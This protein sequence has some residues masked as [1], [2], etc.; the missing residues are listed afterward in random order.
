[1]VR[2]ANFGS[3]HQAL[4]SSSPTAVPTLH[5]H[6][7]GAKGFGMSLVQHGKTIQLN[8]RD[9]SPE[10]KIPTVEDI[11]DSLESLLPETNMPSLRDSELAMAGEATSSSSNLFKTLLYSFTN[12]FAGPREVP[13]RS[14]MQLVREQHEMRTQL[15]E[16]IKSSQSG[17]AKS[18]ADNFF[19][20]AVEGCDADAV[21]TIIHHTKDNPSMA[22]DPNEIACNFEGR[23]F[24][25]IELAA[26]FRNTELVRI[27][28]SPA[29]IPTRHMGEN[30][31]ITGRK[32]R[33][34]LL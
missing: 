8:E 11:T 2:D 30:M 14:L 16:Y 13:R 27:L 4:V 25:P 28:E 31:T 22:I 9:H 19:R 29:Q 23:L 20:A 10:M 21:A 18:L 1:M 26:R 15:F 6:L 7:H 24:T 17:I 32:V 12:D 34:G 33:S 5:G 3:D